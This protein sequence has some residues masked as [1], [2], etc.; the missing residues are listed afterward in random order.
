MRIKAKGRLS[1]PGPSGRHYLLQDKDEITVDPA[2]EEEAAKWVK[3][4]WVT[5]VD[6]GEDHEP[7]PVAVKLQNG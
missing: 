4:G 7:K 6:T 3:A 1:T 5:N 2:D